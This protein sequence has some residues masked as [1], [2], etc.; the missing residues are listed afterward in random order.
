MGVCEKVRVHIHTCMC[1][2]VYV[3]ACVSETELVENIN[4]LLAELLCSEKFNI[5]TGLCASQTACVSTKTCLSLCQVLSTY[6]LMKFYL[7]IYFRLS[8]LH[9]VSAYFRY[10]GSYI[11]GF[12]SS[13]FKQNISETQLKASS[14]LINLF[15]LIRHPRLQILVCSFTCLP[16]IA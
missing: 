3:C 6:R 14:S 8:N 15:A 7:K 1:S 10:T 5:K 9:F 4:S 13:L 16:I 11:V 12:K 2:C